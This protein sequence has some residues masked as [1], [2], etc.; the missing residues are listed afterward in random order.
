MAQP[1]IAG[2]GPFLVHLPT[3]S[4]NACFQC[5][6]STAGSP[7]A[8]RPRNEWAVIQKGESRLKAAAARIGR[9]T[10]ASHFKDSTLAPAMDLTPSQVGPY[11]LPGDWEPALLNHRT[12]L[13]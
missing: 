13:I 10:V 5:N 6:R 1:A 7:L 3:V 12:G 4:R 2:E 8:Q 11:L 9:P